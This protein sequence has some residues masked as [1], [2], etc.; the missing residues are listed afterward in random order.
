MTFSLIGRCERTGMFGI[1]ISTG[2]MAVGS[3]CI[4]VAPNVGAV[5]SQA[6]SN[7]RLGHLGLA[8]L[9]QG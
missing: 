3:R 4:H 9:R 6:S 5:I 7:P 2:E 1:A 8:L